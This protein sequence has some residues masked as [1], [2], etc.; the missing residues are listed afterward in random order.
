MSA[1]KRIGPQWPNNRFQTSG[2]ASVSLI[3]D[4]P[5]TVPAKRV[6]GVQPES[7]PA[8]VKLYEQGASIRQIASMFHHEARS[9]STALKAAGV[10]LRMH[11]ARPA[12]ETIIDCREGR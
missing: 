10:Q 2:A 4:N 12:R 5:A 7:V 11:T 8:I 3:K 6:K 1:F 9:V